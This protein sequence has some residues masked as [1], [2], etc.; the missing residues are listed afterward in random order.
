[1]FPNYYFICFRSFEQDPL[2]PM[3]L[4]PIA[5][6]LVVLK[7]GVLSVRTPPPKKKGTSAF[8][9][10]DIYYPTDV[11]PSSILGL[12]H[13]LITFA[14]ES[15]NYGTT[16]MSRRVSGQKAARE[17]LTNAPFCDPMQI[18]FAMDYWTRSPT[19]L[20]L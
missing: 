3:Y 10:C 9:M 17:C 7:E 8:A 13:I 14:N 15:S 12:H 6:Y 16:S 4:Q 20:P 18:G 11:S 5:I 2:S 19:P 1:V